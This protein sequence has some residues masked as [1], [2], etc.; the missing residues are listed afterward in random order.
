[1]NHHHLAVLT[2][3]VTLVSPRASLGKRATMHG[4]VAC[5]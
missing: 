4:E 2:A 1:M 3:L 5:S